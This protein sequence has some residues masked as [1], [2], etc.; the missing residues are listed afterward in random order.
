[1]AEL[2]EITDAALRAGVVIYTID[3]R[4]LFLGL[5]GVTNDVPF[6]KQNRLESANLREGPASQDALNALAEDTGGRALRNQNYFDK[7]V[8]KILDETSNYYLVAWR[9]NRRRDRDHV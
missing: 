7:W 1:M 2:N 3:A 6:D 5:P 4:G 8:N 9:P